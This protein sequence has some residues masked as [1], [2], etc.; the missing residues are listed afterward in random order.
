MA[1]KCDDGGEFI[2]PFSF[3]EYSPCWVFLASE[4]D[5]ILSGA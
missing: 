2:L 1:A 5:M 4:S 3:Q